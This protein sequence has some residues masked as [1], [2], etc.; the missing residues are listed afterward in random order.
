M[1]QNFPL[2]I[3]VFKV[4]K[5]SK[6]VNISENKAKVTHDKHIVSLGGFEIENAAVVAPVAG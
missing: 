2:R 5:H 3:S 1:L 6:N 4:M